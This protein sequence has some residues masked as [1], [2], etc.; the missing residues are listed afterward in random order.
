MIVATPCRVVRQKGGC[1]WGTATTSPSPR[2]HCRTSHCFV[3]RTKGGSWLAT[4]K[5][6]KV[7]A[8]QT[9]SRGS[10]RPVRAAFV[11]G[12]AVPPQPQPHPR[13]PSDATTAMAA[14][15][16]VAL[17]AAAV[18]TMEETHPSTFYCCYLLFCCCCCVC[19]WNGD[20]RRRASGRLASL[21]TERTT[22]QARL[23]LQL[24][25]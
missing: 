9:M 12:C 25:L 7:T 11:L 22:I 3:A 21:R 24:S 18:D 8:R 23:H 10:P 5:A 16:D 20:R 13:R 15:I 19:C 14:T 4:R 17:P 1:W 2:R 6:V